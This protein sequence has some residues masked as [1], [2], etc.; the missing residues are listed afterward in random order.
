MYSAV[1]IQKKEDLVSF[2]YNSGIMQVMYVFGIFLLLCI[3]KRY[4][5]RNMRKYSNRLW[6]GALKKHKIASKLDY[7]VIALTLYLMCPRLFGGDVYVIMEKI[8]TIL[9]IISST[10]LFISL[11]NVMH[12]IYN[13]VLTVGQKVPIRGYIDLMKII[14]LTFSLILIVTAITGTSPMNVFAGLGALSALILIIFKDSILG[15]VSNIQLA[16]YDIIRIGEWIDMP[17]NNVSGRVLDIRLNT[18]QIQNFN[19]SIVTVPSY[20]IITKGVTNWRGMYDSGG[21]RIKKVIFIDLNS[22]KICDKE[23]VK[24]IVKKYSMQE[25]MADQHDTVAISNAMLFRLHLK[26][27]ITNHPGI[28][29]NQSFILEVRYREITEYGLPLEIYAFSKSTVWNT[30]EGTSSEILE[31]AVSMLPKFS[32]RC[33]QRTN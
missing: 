19:K 27:Y 29:H 6:Y 33:Y 21:R 15:F 11:L 30:Y 8:F 24:S 23:T 10:L 16:V 12:T 26:Q 13:K 31:Y 1:F 4:I 22:V 28:I 32:L 14:V 25:I 5:V 9:L 17:S 3:L 2:L 20:D 7:I 18:V